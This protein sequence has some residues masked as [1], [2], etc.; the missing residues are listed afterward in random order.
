MK[1]IAMSVLF[2]AACG[3]SGRLPGPIPGKK[4]ACNEGHSCPG[5]QACD[6]SCCGGP[7][8]SSGDFYAERP[9]DPPSYACVDGP[10]QVLGVG[11]VAC[12]GPVLAGGLT[13]ARC[14]KDWKL[15]VNDDSLATTPAGFYLSAQHA[16]MRRS[17]PIYYNAICGFIDSS[18][19]STNSTRYLF[20]KGTQP[21]TEDAINKCGNFAKALQCW[22]GY[23]G[24]E[25]QNG[26]NCP[27]V[28]GDERDVAQI[29]GGSGVLCCYSP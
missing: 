22:T 13:D 4:Y 24:Q 29:S 25:K 23:A 27:F 14:G 6:R 1:R 18:A 28:S 12:P 7:P 20:G 2:V 10:G 8:C 15:C 11:M 26:V 16:V 17:P 19:T 5:S 21:G 3:A 9:D